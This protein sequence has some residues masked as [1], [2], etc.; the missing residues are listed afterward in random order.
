MRRCP[1][2]GVAAGGFKGRVGGDSGR[3]HHQGGSQQAAI[4]QMRKQKT[5][6]RF[7]NTW[8][9]LSA[10]TPTACTWLIAW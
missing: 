2:C 6:Y 3:D 10:A 9:T 7:W 1:R 4:E 8:A 5:A